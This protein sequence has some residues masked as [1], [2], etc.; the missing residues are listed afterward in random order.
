MTLSDAFPRENQPRQEPRL[1]VAH[2]GW[3][4]GQ[5]SVHLPFRCS[6]G[7]EGCFSQRCSAGSFGEGFL[8]P[9]FSLVSMAASPRQVGSGARWSMGAPNEGHGG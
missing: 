3:W 5:L 7:R 6:P 1:S 4:R 2:R 9:V 8:L